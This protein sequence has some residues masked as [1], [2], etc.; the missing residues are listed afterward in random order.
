MQPQLHPVC[1]SLT[2]LMPLHHPG[3]T[4]QQVSRTGAPGCGAACIA[5]MPVASSAPVAVVHGF[6]T[7]ARGVTSAARVGVAGLRVVPR[8][9][10]AVCCVVCRVVNQLLT[11][12]DGVEGLTGVAVLAATSRPDLIDAALLRP[13]GRLS[14]SGCCCCCCGFL[15]VSTLRAD[16]S[17]GAA[18]RG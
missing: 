14:G 18:A 5:Y 1:C 3:G 6:V 2:S 9:R 15:P 16:D 17:C 12:L 11:E 4:T 10:E 7:G 13:G 8:F